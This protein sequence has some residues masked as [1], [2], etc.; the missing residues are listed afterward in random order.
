MKLQIEQIK[1]KAANKN[2]NWEIFDIKQ[3]S[4][5]LRSRKLEQGHLDRCL[6]HLIK[7]QARNTHWSLLATMMRVIKTP[8]LRLLL[9]RSSSCKHSHKPIVR[10]CCVFLI[11]TPASRMITNTWWLLWSC[12][13]A[14]SWSC[15][16]YC[17]DLGRCVSKRIKQNGPM[18]S[19][20][21]Y[22]INWLR[23]LWPWKNTMWLIEISSHKTFYIV[24]LIDLTRLLT[25]VGPNF[26][27]PSRLNSTQ[28]E[29]HQ[30]IGHVWYLILYLAEI[31]FFCDL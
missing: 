20:F 15:W 9:E 6:P 22:W 28:L 23:D 11:S 19:Y 27:N 31:Y 17:I 25:W 7:R 29:A 24:R 2:Y 1:D 8:S 10:D 3:V 26:S 16:K 21:T 13:I 30:H 18:K 14:I 12:V 4:V 5:P